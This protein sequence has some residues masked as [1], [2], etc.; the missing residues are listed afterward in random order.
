MQDFEKLGADVTVS[1]VSLAWVPWWVGDGGSAR[2][3]R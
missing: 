1:G 3:A 2:P